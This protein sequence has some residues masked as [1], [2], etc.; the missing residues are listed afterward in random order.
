MKI[1]QKKKA[2]L[3][4]LLSELWKATKPILLVCLIVQATMTILLFK[5]YLER[6]DMLEV[7]FA[8]HY[9]EYHDFKDYILNNKLNLVQTSYET[10]NM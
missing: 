7:I 3:K 10:F 2:T 8:E 1:V 4:T 5:T 6:V 9:D